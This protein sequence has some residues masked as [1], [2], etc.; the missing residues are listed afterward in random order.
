MWLFTINLKSYEKLWKWINDG[1][2]EPAITEA[3]EEQTPR[4]ERK[5]KQRWK[6]MYFG[7]YGKKW[8]QVNI[9]EKIRDIG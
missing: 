3:A 8:R 2:S 6:T 7:P 9:F 5:I 4:N 1:Q